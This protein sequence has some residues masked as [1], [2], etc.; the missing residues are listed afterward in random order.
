[1]RGGA[2]EREG[3]GKER[4]SGGRESRGDASELVRR[5]GRAGRMGGRRGGGT[6]AVERRNV[7]LSVSRDETLSFISLHACLHIVA[8]ARSR[9]D[10]ESR[11]P[12]AAS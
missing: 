9:A 11:P 7:K 2:R 1:M 8:F 3:A 12:R 5:A 4:R 10:A 6:T